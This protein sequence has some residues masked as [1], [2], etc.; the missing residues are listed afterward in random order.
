M[1]SGAGIDH[2]VSG[3]GRRYADLPNAFVYRDKLVPD[4]T[5]NGRTPTGLSFVDPKAD[6]T[7]RAGDI[8]A[9]NQGMMTFAGSGRQGVAEFTPVNRSA[10]S[11]EMRRRLSDL[12]IAPRNADGEAPANTEAAPSAPPANP[13]PQRSQAS[14]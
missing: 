8:V 6:P 13:R 10:V 12:K 1:F 3:D 4:C 7:L 2:A 11:E 5:C 14:R 9:T